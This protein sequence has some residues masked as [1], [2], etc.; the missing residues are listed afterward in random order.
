MGQKKILPNSGNSAIESIAIAL[1]EQF[2]T[3]KLKK[4]DSFSSGGGENYIGVDACIEYAALDAYRIT[5]EKMFFFHD[6]ESSE[7][8]NSTVRDEVL[9]GLFLMSTALGIDFIPNFSK[10]L[11]QSITMKEVEDF[12]G[13]RLSVLLSHLNISISPETCSIGQISCMKLLGFDVGPSFAT[14]YESVA[15]LEEVLAGVAMVL[16]LGSLVKLT[17]SKLPTLDSL[18]YPAGSVLYV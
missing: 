3:L 6:L 18:V 5:Q 14:S 8:E 10:G 16:Y 12:G 11:F 13:F 9:R 17:E 2:S 1:F 7:C 15:K 4:M